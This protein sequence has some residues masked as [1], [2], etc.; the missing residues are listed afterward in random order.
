M[1]DANATMFAHDRE[2]LFYPAAPGTV[3]LI[4]LSDL[5]RYTGDPADFEATTETTDLAGML[6]ADWGPDAV[7]VARTLYP[8]GHRPKTVPA[9]FAS[10]DTDARGEDIE[11]DFADALE[12]W[13]DWCD[14]QVSAEDGEVTL[15]ATAADLQ[16]AAQ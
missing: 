12:A 3:F 16:A 4:L 9:L 13:A 8:I 14:E 15:T 6:L 2:F 11:Q 1:T 5:A 7:D 10:T